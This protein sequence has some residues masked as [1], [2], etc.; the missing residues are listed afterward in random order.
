MRHPGIGAQHSSTSFLCAAAT[1]DAST[2][3]FH[4]YWTLM[5]T[6]DMSWRAGDGDV[7]HARSVDARV[8]VPVKDRHLTLWE[9]KSF[10]ERNLEPTV[11]LDLF[12]ELTTRSAE[13]AGRDVEIAP[14]PV[15]LA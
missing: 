2:P 10:A 13:V 12:P 15:D 6:W 11:L 8:G 14:S 4:A 9:K 3:S 5:I 1:V 7:C